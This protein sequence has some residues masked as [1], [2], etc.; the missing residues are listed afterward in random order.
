MVAVL[1]RAQHRV[2]VVVL[3]GQQPV[4]VGGVRTQM[5]AVDLVRQVGRVG[6]VVTPYAE[7]CSSFVGG[8][9]RHVEHM[10]HRPCRVEAYVIA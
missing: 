5:R 4:E 3:A 2:R 6:H 1:V 7:G 10:R 9:L 8:K